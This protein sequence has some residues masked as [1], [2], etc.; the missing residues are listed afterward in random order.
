MLMHTWSEDGVDQTLRSLFPPPTGRKSMTYK[1]LYL[2]RR[3]RTI[4]WADWPRTWKSHAIFASQFPA[5]S[6]TFNWLR[7]T[8]RVD[9]P[10]LGD[11]PVS[12]KHDGVCVA[13]APELD[14]FYG[15]SLS[16]EHRALI[17]QDELR[18]FDRYVPEFSFYCTESRVVD[19]PLGEAAIFRFLR[20]RADVS[21]DA[22]DTHL[23]GEH[24][25]LCKDLSGALAVQRWAS[26]RRST[27]RHGTSLSKRSTNV[28]SHLSG[29]P[30]KR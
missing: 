1:L 16:P 4:S 17:D 13:E 23:E 29:T 7:Y 10:T 26:T 2:A 28:G 15:R 6:G 21:R 8:T 11:L 3:A 30:L 5:M 14:T 27:L 20:R 25:R 12:N 24:A 19:G 18:V 22:F 9:D